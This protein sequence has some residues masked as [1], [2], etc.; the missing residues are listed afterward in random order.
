[1]TQKAFTCERPMH[2]RANDVPNKSVLV[3]AFAVM[4]YQA[5]CLTSILIDSIAYETE[6]SV[7]R[8]SLSSVRRVIGN[9]GNGHWIAGKMNLS[10]NSC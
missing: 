10:T 1:M 5:K 2:G 3:L 9:M 7:S 8:G 6:V 4:S